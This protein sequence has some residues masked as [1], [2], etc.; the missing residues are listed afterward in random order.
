MIS[1]VMVSYFT[2]PALGAAVA[3]VLAEPD[4]A[5]LILVDNGNTPAVTAALAAQ[6]AQEPRL[7]LVTG[8]GNIG[9][10]AGCNRGAAE[11]KG[12][13]LLLLNPDARLAP[14]ALARLRAE[15][16][17]LPRPFL[18]GG[19]IVDDEG[20][21]Q[22]PTHRTAREQRGGRRHALTPLRALVEGLGLYRLGLGRWRLNRHQ[23]PAPEAAVPMG[24]VSGALMA[25]PLADYRALG[26][27]DAGYF[28]HVED[29]DLCRRM[30]AAGGRVV[31]APSVV[32]VHAGGTSAAPAAFVERHKARGLRRYFRMHRPKTRGAGLLWDAL[33]SVVVAAAWV[34]VYRGRRGAAQGKAGRNGPGA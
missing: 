27:L 16:A 28:L 10:A 34:R 9:F 18:I 33:A 21:N 8:H 26:G 24:A 7:T 25:L 14:G 5:E 29:L 4:A 19:R 1:V 2:G 22:T 23:E 20:P 31:Y 13:L 32:A 15:A 17:A 6:A 30:H 3:S 11:A 12:D